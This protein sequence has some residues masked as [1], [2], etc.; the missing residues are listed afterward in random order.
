MHR[1][2]E[3]GYEVRSLH[4]TLP[5]TLAVCL[6]AVH[7]V[8]GSTTMGVHHWHGAELLTGADHRACHAQGGLA[9]KHLLQLHV[10]VI[11]P[12]WGA[13]HRGRVGSSLLQ[14][15]RAPQCE[16]VTTGKGVLRVGRVEKRVL[17]ESNKGT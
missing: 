7:A 2:L 11:V 5:T 4:Q 1:G 16:L 12:A 15:C 17:C 10:V 9:A 8:R 14:L 3:V 13:Q 6:H